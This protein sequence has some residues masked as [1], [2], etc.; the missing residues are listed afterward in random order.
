M[1][2]QIRDLRLQVSQ[3]SP[4]ESSECSASEERTSRGICRQRPS[5]ISTASRTFEPFGLQR[6]CTVGNPLATSPLTFCARVNCSFVLRALQNLG[7]SWPTWANARV[8]CSIGMRV[9]A[10]LVAR[11]LESRVPSHPAMLMRI[12]QFAA[13]LLARVATRHLRND[14]DG[15][16]GGS[17][18]DKTPT[19]EGFWCRGGWVRES[20]P[21]RRRLLPESRISN[22]SDVV[23]LKR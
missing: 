12:V 5:V 11:L 6:G 16:G 23:E 18:S 17:C 20:D 1:Q 10:I 14:N 7:R 4:S 19:C 13:L 9:R 8:T 2:V 22:S 21:R 15:T 3:V